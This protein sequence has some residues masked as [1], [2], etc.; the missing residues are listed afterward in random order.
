MPARLNTETRVV[1]GNRIIIVGT[2]RGWRFGPAEGKWYIG[3]FILAIIILLYNLAWPWAYETV[4]GHSWRFR[5][6]PAVQTTTV[7]PTSTPSVV[8]P[9][10]ALLQSEE[11]R[12]EKYKQELRRQY[13]GQ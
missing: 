2:D 9:Q 4:N 6:V 12:A 11:E 10:P 13:G 3:M 5:N 8:T 1:Q 7:P